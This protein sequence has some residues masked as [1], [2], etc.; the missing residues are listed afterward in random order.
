MPALLNHLWQST[1]F[2]GAAGLMTLALARHGA[3]VRYG[4]WFAASLK[5][6][7]PFSTLA[8]LGGHI[9]WAG[10]AGAVVPNLLDRMVEPFA[11][12][13]AVLPGLM[14]VAPAGGLPLSAWSGFAGHLQLLWIGVWATGALAVGICWLLRWLRIRAI[15]RQAAPL[16]LDAPSP[17]RESQQQVE[18]GVV[19]FFRPILQLPAG[20]ARY[21]NPDQ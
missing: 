4:L 8:A 3:H 11:A 13:P 6:L 19:G 7:I 20:I 16:P 18:P 15:V 1:L 2:A 12:E 10:A 5:F 9:R 14:K 21:L 17:A